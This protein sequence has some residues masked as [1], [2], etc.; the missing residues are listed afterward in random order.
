MKNEEFIPKF[1]LLLIFGIYFIVN[2]CNEPS[3]K[4]D[5]ILI[6][7][8][9]QDNIDCDNALRKEQQEKIIR[10][11]SLFEKPE[12]LTKTK[13]DSIRKEYQKL[14]DR[15]I[16]MKQVCRSEYLKLAELLHAL[17]STILI[18]KSEEAIN[19]TL[20]NRKKWNRDKENKFSE[21]E[22]NYSRKYDKGE[23]GEDM[24]MIVYREMSEI[25]YKRINEIMPRQ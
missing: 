8:K 1:L 11:E 16:L 18:N 4:N 25:L 23:W 2:S 22:E 15:G 3:A 14:A 7:N 5:K 13:L 21:L 24:Y 17:D 20:K 10:M 12:K 6:D 9:I 19:T